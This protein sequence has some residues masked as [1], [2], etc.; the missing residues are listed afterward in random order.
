M[1]CW[2]NGGESPKLAAEAHDCDQGAW[3]GPRGGQMGCCGLQEADS[4]SLRVALLVPGSVAPITATCKRVQG[5][6]EGMREREKHR[7]Q[8]QGHAIPTQNLCYGAQMSWAASAPV[9]ALFLTLGRLSKSSSKIQCSE[10]L[11]RV[12]LFGKRSCQWQAGVPISKATF[13]K[14][15]W[16]TR[17]QQEV[18]NQGDAEPE[19]NLSSMVEWTETTP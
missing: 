7:C 18:P 3:A 13:S 1:H 16:H 2:R 19:E 15:S 11:L 10:S 17:W 5:G 6:R 8:Q 9:P 14:P 4:P 12:Q